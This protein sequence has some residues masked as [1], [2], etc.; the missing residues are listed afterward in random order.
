MK[1]FLFNVIEDAKNVFFQIV[2]FVRHA[3]LEL[4]YFPYF[5]THLFHFG[6]KIIRK[7]VKIK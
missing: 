5:S 7:A 2:V 6:V 1:P 4:S 3:N